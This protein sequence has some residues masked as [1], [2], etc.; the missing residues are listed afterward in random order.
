MRRKPILFV[1][2]GLVLVSLLAVAARGLEQV[3]ARQVLYD[4]LD[5][6]LLASQ[7]SKDTV[8]WTKPVAA[9][10]RPFTSFDEEKL[11]RTISEAWAAFAAAE[12]SGEIAFLPDYF[13]GVALARAREAA[14]SARDTRTR[15]VNLTYAGSPVFYH[16]DG[17]VFQARFDTLSVRFAEKAD[18]LAFFRATRDVNITTLMNESSGWRVYAH[19]RQAVKEIE[20]Q[21][22]PKVS[23]RLAGINYY[24]AATPWS[25]F[26]D[27]F[28]LAV[29]EHDFDEIVKLGANSVRI[30]LPRETFLGKAREAHLRNLSMLLQ[31]ADERSLFVVPTLFDLKGSYSLAT[32]SDD[33]AYLQQVLPTIDRHPAVAFVD[34]KN[35][36]D[37]DFAIHG[38]GQVEAWLRAMS[39]AHR[40]L[41]PEVP[42]TVGWSAAEHAGIAAGAFDLITYHEYAPLEGLTERLKKVQQ[43]ADG[44]P[45]MITEIG[46]SA[47]SALWGWPGSPRGQAHELSVRLEAL[48]D[49][50]GIFVWTL[51]DFPNPDPAAIGHSPWVRNLQARFGLIDET[52]APRPAAK[53]VKSGFADFLKGQDQ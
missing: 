13:S 32:W 12:G 41:A 19:E 7:Q 50:D 8:R 14:V 49:A 11:G 37:L 44:K 51:H 31:A 5:E 34:L 47:W 30:F 24:P 28:D 48:A 2:V 6:A 20:H 9:L 46:A 16:L 36:P 22:A 18:G 27:H 4:Y 25:A 45:V 53:I 33:T 17:S 21:A 1:L 26:W 23:S 35:E 42:L 40:E 15:M 38:R 43:L 10:S 29:I 3:Q 52:G 39:V